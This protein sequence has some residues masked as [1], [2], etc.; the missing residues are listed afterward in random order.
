MIEKKLICSFVPAGTNVMEYHEKD[1]SGFTYLKKGKHD[2]PDEE[3]YAAKDESLFIDVGG[4]LKEGIIDHHQS[5]GFIEDRED[6]GS[7][8]SLLFAFPSLMQAV[9]N[10]EKETVTI[11]VHHG[12]DFD[13][14]LAVYL[15]SYY[16]KNGRFPVYADRMV[17]LANDVDQ[18]SAMI[19]KANPVSLYT[20]A[21]GISHLIFDDETLTFD[22]K[23]QRSLSRGLSLIEYG[24]TRLEEL[25]EKERDVS[26]PVL[27]ASGHP[28]RD[29]AAL[30]VSDF[31]KFMDDLHPVSGITD[32]RSLQLP[33]DDGKVQEVDGLIWE[34]TP[35]CKLHKLW[36]RSYGDS[37]R[38]TGFIFTCIPLV[39][40]EPGEGG[41]RYVLSV[42]PDEG[43]HLKGLGKRLELVE[44]EAE[45]SGVCP[46]S[47][48]RNRGRRRYEEEWCNNDDPW[49][50]GRG[51]HYTI[52]D[53]PKRKSMISFDKVKEIVLSFQVPVI[54]EGRSDCILPFEFD[55]HAYES[56]IRHLGQEGFK[57]PEELGRRAKDYFRPYIQG[58][59]FDKKSGTPYAW[60]HFCSVFEISHGDQV[61]KQWLIIFKYGVGF[62]ISESVTTV[63]PGEERPVD[64]FI[65]QNIGHE[66]AIYEALKNRDHGATV[67][68]QALS[69]L[70]DVTLPIHFDQPIFYT[71]VSLDKDRFN[72]TFS[73]EAVY[74]LCMNTP[75]R[76]PFSSDS[77]E[78]KELLSDMYYDFNDD[79]VYGLSKKGGV[80]FHLQGDDLRIPEHEKNYLDEVKNELLHKFQ[81]FEFYIFLLALHQRYCLMH[82]SREL[83]NLGEKKRYRDIARLRS[84]VLEFIVQGWFSQITNDEAGMKRYG[85]WEKIFE[86]NKL[87]DEVLDQVSTVDQYYRSRT[88]AKI[89][90]ISSIF[91]PLVFLNVF[92]GIGF[93]QFSAWLSFENPASWTYVLA[94]LGGLS[95]V[96]VIYLKEWHKSLLWGIKKR[97]SK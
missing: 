26:S 35:T 18:G 43:V 19:D 51:H 96:A 25:H 85:R 56:L 83:S 60:N 67:F 2:S 78:M 79:V 23:N 72:Q 50:D 55:A 20:L 13:C 63:S 47:K 89:E 52:I 95:L 76:E 94:I 86:N 59:L 64:L 62:I 6:M 57:T 73:E 9:V 65:N 97:F 11:Y 24:F 88:S 45:E 3:V 49:Y 21:H 37:P 15:A 70:K 77:K 29:E 71:N 5:P 27:I 53:T 54:L 81:S 8:S 32:I 58:Y 87:H 28:F 34:K 91:M 44:Q 38:R 39:M 40:A 48:R 90:N 41:S 80:F 82:F 92:M 17:Q 42:K 12:P 22:Q 75:W 69:G 33:T 36:A 4:E 61:K 68:A 93:I 16:I 46:P 1:W 74:K 30:I 10:S 7:S 66:N 84:S 31:E 14:Y